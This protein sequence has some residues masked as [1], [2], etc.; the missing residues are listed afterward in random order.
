MTTPNPDAE[1]R[2]PLPASVSET[3]RKCA[4]EL[5]R[6][7]HLAFVT[8]EVK[9]VGCA[10]NLDKVTSIISRALT[11]HT[12]TLAAERDALKAESV[13]LS[14][15][16]KENTT[17]RAALDKA[18]EALQRIANPDL[19]EMCSTSRPH[20]WIDLATVALTALN[21]QEQK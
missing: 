20:P 16:L 14:K 5:A 8:P 3:A 7:E 9:Y 6:K 2:A 15:Q 11:A 13:V 18:R 4:L 17:L 10:D 21:Q 19:M 1:K 12:A